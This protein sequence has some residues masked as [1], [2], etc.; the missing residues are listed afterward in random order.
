L[1][2]FVLDTFLETS[3]SHLDGLKFCHISLAT[4]LSASTAP[5]VCV[6][7]GIARICC[8]EGQSWKLSH[9]ALMADFRAGCSSCLMTC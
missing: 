7:S 5:M 3:D 8:E 9:G 1:Y 4:S 2:I 6:C